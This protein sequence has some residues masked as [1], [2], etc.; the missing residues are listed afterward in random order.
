[1]PNRIA[2]NHAAL[3]Q[4]ESGLVGAQV[5]AFLAPPPIPGPHADDVTANA[6]DEREDRRVQAADRERNARNEEPRP[7]RTNEPVASPESAHAQNPSAPRPHRSTWL[8]I[9]QDPGTSSISTIGSEGRS[10][11][12]EAS[13]T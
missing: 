4:D 7:L 3:A 13:W 10:W 12:I 6:V 8:E 5:A 11:H 9:G 1:M 2:A